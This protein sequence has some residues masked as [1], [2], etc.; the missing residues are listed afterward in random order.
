[1]LT[2]K[3]NRFEKN[4]LE[5]SEKVVDLEFFQMHKKANVH[6]LALELEIN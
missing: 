5:F 3:T 6:H 4:P 1:M 2:I